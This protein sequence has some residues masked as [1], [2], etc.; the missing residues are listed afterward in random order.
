MNSVRV[1]LSLAANL[2]WPLYQF[3]VKNAFLHGDLEEEVYMDIP[4]GFEDH[5]TEGKVCKLRKSLYGLKQS[6]R[7]WFAPGKGLYFSKYDHLHVEAYIDADWAGSVTDRRLTSGYCTFVG[8]NLVTWRSKKQ[9][10]VARSSAEAEFRAMAQGVCELLWIKLLLSD[11]GI[12]QTDSMRLYCDNK[13]TINIAH[14]PV[15]HDRTKHVEIDR[16]FIKEKLTSG[17]ICT[18]VW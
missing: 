6:P 4:P 3:D 15:Q 1:L 16:H 10:V 7:A 14:N 5:Q 18:P 9:N 12:D 17:T 11:L 13:A 2:D 8:G